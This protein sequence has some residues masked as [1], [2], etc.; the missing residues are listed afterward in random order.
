MKKITFIIL[1]ILL[2]INTFGQL[3]APYPISGTY[4]PGSSITVSFSADIFFTT[5]TKRYLVFL[6]L[7]NSSGSFSSNTTRLCSLN[8]YNCNNIP[9][10]GRAVGVVSDPENTIYTI[11]GIIPSNIPPGSN[12]RVRVAL[13][14]EI[15]LASCTYATAPA[16]IMNS[17]SLPI[18]A[19]SIIIS[20]PQGFSNT[21]AETYERVTNST[22]YGYSPDAGTNVYRFYVPI[23]GFYRFVIRHGGK[24]KIVGQSADTT[25]PSTQT[26]T[27]TVGNS[28]EI[29]PP[30]D[31]LW[32]DKVN[33][34][35]HQ[36][37]ISGTTCTNEL[38]PTSYF[39]GTPRYVQ[40]PTLVTTQINQLVNP[41]NGMM[42]Y[43]LTSNCVR[44]HVNGIWKCLS[45]Q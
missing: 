10:L 1:G 30:C 15:T 32:I 43:D 8:S 12:Y 14:Q 3:I 21:I 29:N 40:L 23:V 5:P 2:Y 34:A 45:F 27:E 36:V 22:P 39:E 13:L 24:W 41:N 4:Y 42:V 9:S 26:I 25:P 19:P 31:A 44:V 7:S 28:I 35:I 11:D 33:G 16:I 6:Q 20:Q 38:T 37:F 17:V 18:S